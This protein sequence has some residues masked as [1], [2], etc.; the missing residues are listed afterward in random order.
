MNWLCVLAAGLVIY[1]VI[2]AERHSGRAGKQEAV[3]HE[4]ILEIDSL[5]RYR[6]FRPCHFRE[7]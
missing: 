7:K 3:K 4:M 6:C 2:G 1:L 5:R